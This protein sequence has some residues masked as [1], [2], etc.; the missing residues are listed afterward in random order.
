MG[1]ESRDYSRDGRYTASLSG[2]GMDLTPVVKY[3]IIANVVVF[4]LQIILTRPVAPQAAAFDQIWP[5]DEETAEDTDLPTRKNVVAKTDKRQKREQDARKA[6]EAMEE[7]LSRMQ[8]M[9]S[10]IVQEWFQLDPKKTVE[11]GAD[12]AAGDEPRFATSDTALA[13]PV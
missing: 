11:R 8:G 5:D 1:F 7:M 13:H 3:L 4:V 12:L 6:R 10:S 2:W 9:R